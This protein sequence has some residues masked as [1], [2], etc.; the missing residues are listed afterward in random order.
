MT[1]AVILAGGKSRRMGRDKLAL[2]QDGATVLASAVGR[3]EKYFDAVYVSVNDVGRY[4]EITAR[5]IEDIYK[6]CGPMGGLHSALSVCHGEGVFL[7]AADLPFSDPKIALKIIELCGEN[8]ICVTVDG[9]GRFEPLF[10]YYKKCV[11]KTAE[12]LLHSGCFRMAELY[13]RHATRLLT[14]E[15]MG[16]VWNSRAFENMNYPDDYARLLK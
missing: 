15:E 12:E 8:D 2:P 9:S 1:E 10:G 7:S 5:K 13:K 3:F 4:P 16:D 11:L 6:N 14:P